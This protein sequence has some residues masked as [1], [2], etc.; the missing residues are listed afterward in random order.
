MLNMKK[1]LQEVKDKH[2]KKSVDCPTCGATMYVWKDPLNGKPRDGGRP[3]CEACGYKDQQKRNDI[4]TNQRYITSLKKRALLFFKNGSIVPDKELFTKSLSNFKPVNQETKIAL[5]TAKRYSKEIIKGGKHHLILS[6]N[7]G[8]GKSHLSMGVCWQVL[9]DSNYDMK[10]LFINY[11]ELLEQLKF[12]FGDEQARK[13]LQGDLIADIK[14]IDLVVIDDLGA[15]LG[16][17]VNKG[18]SNY[19]NDVLYSILEARQNKALIVNTNLSGKEVKKYYGERVVS[20]ILNNS[21]GFSIRFEQTTDKRRFEL[22][23]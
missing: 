10:C 23:I 18:A 13:R 3:T 8:V 5:N 1:G 4:E 16:G 20:R 19:N 17:V 21:K 2:W 15:E 12:S 11:R 6:G 7:A 14:T 9:E 22:E